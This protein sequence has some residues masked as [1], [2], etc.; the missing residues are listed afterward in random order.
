MSILKLSKPSSLIRCRK[1]V[2]VRDAMGHFFFF[3]PPPQFDMSTKMILG[4][5]EKKVNDPRHDFE[6]L[7]SCIDL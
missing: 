3:S 1:Y 5:S 7:D 6:L 4:G 2:R